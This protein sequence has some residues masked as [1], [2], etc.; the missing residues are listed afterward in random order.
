MTPETNIL[1][2]LLGRA[3]FYLLIVAIVLFSLFP[4]YWAL[5]SSFKGEQELFEPASYLPRN[6]TTINY[7]G[8]FSNGNFMQALFNS[9]WV[10]AAVVLL[11]LVVGAFAAYALGRLQFRGRTA[12]MYIVLAMTMF[13]QI[14]IL[15][16]LF[17]TVREIGV[18][19]SPLSLILTYPIF[20]LPFT[21]W[22]LTSFFK[23]L[24]DEIEQAALVDGATGFQTFYMIM[25]P[26]TAPALVTTGLLA[27][28]A[29]W[30]EYL[31]ALTFTLTNRA[32]QTVPV[33][34]AQ[35]NGMVARQEPIAEV[36]AA[37]MVVTLPLIVLVVVFQKRI[38]A[39]LTA[40]AVKG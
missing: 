37:A 39:G 5:N 25:L 9:A 17:T 6:F 38:V 30:N 13:P 16:G 29:A 31:Y 2:K 26:L 34:I 10:S 33:A 19:G 18:Y 28:I 40:G 36:M 21:V 14:S 32:A 35:F 8:V 20:T 12:M 1:N 15:S 23:G 24:P 4:F 7:Q 11:S 22:V 27:F 3:G